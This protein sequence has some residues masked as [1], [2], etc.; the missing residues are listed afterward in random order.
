MELFWL[1][2]TLHIICDEIEAEEEGCL[3]IPDIR[4]DI[5][6]P[7]GIRISGW[8]ATG[9]PIEMESDQFIARIWQHEN[10]HLD[11]ILILDKMN[12]MDRIVN[13]RQIKYLERAI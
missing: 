1:N 4:C 11:G 5:K 10:D 6:R 3:S 12:A 8:D 13:R 9:K 7:I 2:P